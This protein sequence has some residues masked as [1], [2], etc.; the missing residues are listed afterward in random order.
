VQ[1][2]WELRRERQ[3]IHSWRRGGGGEFS[4]LYIPCWS[5]T[6]GAAL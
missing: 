6:L 5:L 4:A 2:G 1:V 3:G